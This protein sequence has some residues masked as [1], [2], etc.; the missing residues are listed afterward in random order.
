MVVLHVVRFHYPDRIM[1]HSVASLVFLALGGAFCAVIFLRKGEADGVQWLTGYLLEVMN[2]LEN[3]FVFWAMAKAFGLPKPHLITAI[4][5]LMWNQILFDTIF[6]MGM[7]DWLRQ[8]RFLPY[9]LGVW[10]IYVAYINA[11]VGAA[12]HQ[13]EH[14]CNTGMGL[15]LTTHLGDRFWPSY[16][17]KGNIFVVKGDKLC[18][19]LLGP[20]LACY[21]LAGIFLEVDVVLT[22]LEELP[23]RYLS[24]T[25]SAIGSCVLFELFFTVEQHTAGY[26][27]MKYGLAFVTAILGIE[28]LLNEIYMVP[29]LA[30]CVMMVVVFSACAL[31]SAFTSLGASPTE[32]EAGVEEVNEVLAEGCGECPSTLEPP[33]QEGS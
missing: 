30:N 26:P 5:V 28:M 9:I 11:F 6:F 14:P 18:V 22:K 16:D 19:S 21:A 29:V 4:M 8:F 27:L 15:W 1:S 33:P 13:I 24:Y 23:N 25:S 20:V 10:L 3:F 7:A 32:E 12:A 2:I 17:K 31:L